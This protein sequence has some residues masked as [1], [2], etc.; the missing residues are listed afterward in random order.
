MNRSTFLGALAF[1]LLTLSMAAQVPGNVMSWVYQIRVPTGTATSFVLEE[2]DKQYIFTANH[3][4]EDLGDHAKIE[5]MSDGKW[6]PTRS[7]DFAW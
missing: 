1:S 3:V 5:L 6:G 4:V 7:E 2:G